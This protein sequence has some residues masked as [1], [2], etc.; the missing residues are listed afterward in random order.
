MISKK[1]FLQTVSLLL[2]LCSLTLT[3]GCVKKTGELKVGDK[4]RLLSGI[5]LDYDS[6]FFDDFTDG[7]SYDDWYINNQAWGIGN[8]GVVPQNV[9][10]T[11]DGVLVLSGNGEYYTEGDIRGVGARKDGTLTGA[12]LTSKFLTAPGRYQI[13]MKVLPRLGACSAFW[14]YANDSK[15]GGNHEIDIELPGGKSSSMI[16][17][18][19]VLNTNY[20]TEKMNNSQDNVVVDDNGIA[21]ALNDGEWHTFGFDWYTCETGEDV[22]L[23]GEDANMGKVVYYIDGKITA[24]SDFFVPYYQARLWVG[25]WFPNNESFVGNADFESDC[26]YV[27]WVEYIPFKNQPYVEFEPQLGQTMVAEK[28]EYPTTPVAT[29]SVNKIANGD[30]EYVR[31]NADNSGFILSLDPIPI[32]EENIIR[33]RIK[34]GILSNNPSIDEVSLK[35]AV[36]LAYK[37]YYN[38]PVTEFSN[39]S[40]DIGYNGSCGATLSDYAC[41]SQVIDSVYSGFK[42]TVSFNAKGKGKLVLSFM[43]LGQKNRE[44]ALGKLVI[45]INSTEWQSFNGEMIAPNGTKE[46]WVEF[47]AGLDNTVSVDNVSLKLF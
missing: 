37:E 12:A 44:N 36:N 14:T 7:V 22:S 31:K 23:L 40:T 4:I 9:N 25:V 38:L 28:S 16:T 27:D 41:L 46:I 42:S 8:G 35:Q 20:I 15:T 32:D 2:A 47:I 18:Q 24:I 19:N 10:Y 11:D 1:R 29:A 43:E 39:I 30:F 45:D 13:K 34:Q 5:E 3:V 21:V 26:M 6:A 33:D 17:F